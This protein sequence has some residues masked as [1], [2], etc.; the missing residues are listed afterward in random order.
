MSDY[1]DLEREKTE[2]KGQV[3]MLKNQLL[4]AQEEVRLVRA[5]LDGLLSQS[6][7]LIIICVSSANLELLPFWILLCKVS[8]V[9]TFVGYCWTSAAFLSFFNIATDL[10]DRNAKFFVYYLL[11]L[12]LTKPS[13]EELALQIELQKERNA[14]RMDKEEHDGQKQALQDQLQSEVRQCSE[15]LLYVN[16]YSKVFCN[17]C[18]S[19]CF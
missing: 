9:L 17:L 8:L 19:A 18:G 4:E 10:A 7:F 14:H 3:H 13:K 15:L 6:N 11:L 5:G 2:L 16:N 12:D 1:S